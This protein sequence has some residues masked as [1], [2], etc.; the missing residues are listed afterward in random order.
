MSDKPRILVQLDPDTH[1]SVFDSVVAIDSSVDHLLRFGGVESVQVQALVHGAIFTRGVPDLKSTAIFIGGSDVSLGESLCK[2]VVGSFFGPMRVSVM[3]DSNGANSTA[4]AAVL[5]CAKHISLDQ[6]KVAVLA[7]TGPVGRRVA[8]LVAGK[9]SHVFLHSRTAAKGSQCKGELVEGGVPADK[10]TVISFEDRDSFH[11]ALSEADGIVAC[12]AAGVQ[13]LSAAELEQAT[14]VKVV[15]DLNAVPP[16]GIE[17]IGATDK[18]VARGSRFDYGALGAGGL[19][20]KIH[21][22]AIKRLFERNDYILDA[23]EMLEIG[24]TL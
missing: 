1:P 16:Q 12:G 15:V 19:K 5:C 8:R 23:E 7:G 21:K 14:K 10:I 18:G 17:G 13:L 2:A 6:S 22:A 9:G 3:L 4:A 24:S 20:M 11:A